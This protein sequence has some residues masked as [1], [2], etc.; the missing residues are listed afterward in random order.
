MEV[1]IHQSVKLTTS[2]SDVVLN[3]NEIIRA[4]LGNKGENGKAKSK[5]TMLTRFTSLPKSIANL[6]GFGSSF[7]HQFTV[8]DHNGDGVN[9]VT[10]VGT[11]KFEIID[12]SG[13]S[14]AKSQEGGSK[15]SISVP[16][17]DYNLEIYNA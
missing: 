11:Q 6:A 9:C 17:G 1:S 13:A 10:V 5:R 2:A 14:I 12:V 8:D 15:L 4:K 3:L 16:K 7:R